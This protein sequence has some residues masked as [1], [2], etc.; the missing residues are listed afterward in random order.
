M[1]DV[2]EAKFERPVSDD[3][4]D[5]GR[6]LAAASTKGREKTKEREEDKDY[7]AI[8]TRNCVCEQQHLKELSPQLEAN[9]GVLVY[10]YLPQSE[11]L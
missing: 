4:L 7:G 8:P 2:W 6:G 3:E 11:H 9:A 5:G 10:L 1:L